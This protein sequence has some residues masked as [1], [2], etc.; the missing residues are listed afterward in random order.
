MPRGSDAEGPCAKAGGA[1]ERQ[2]CL[3]VKE[4]PAQ[5][6]E[7]IR[8]APKGDDEPP[9]SPHPLSASWQLLSHAPT[10][11]HGLT[12]GPKAMDQQTID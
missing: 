8:G 5:G 1:L 3:P 9:A 12:T 2:W 7:L 4:G 6:S 10:R 11:T